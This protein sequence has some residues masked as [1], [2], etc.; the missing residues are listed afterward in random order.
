[1]IT[2]TIIAIDVWS[3]GSIFLSILSGCKPYFK[4]AED[5]YVLAEL[6]NIFGSKRMIAAAANIGF[7]ETNI[8]I[9]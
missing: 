1:M 5:L 6:I 9:P 3:V 2:K 8:I 7:Q 4:P